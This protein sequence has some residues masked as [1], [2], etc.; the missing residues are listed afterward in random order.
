MIGAATAATRNRCARLPSATKGGAN[1]SRLRRSRFD[2]GSEL[3]GG[4]AESTLAGRVLV[5]AL[6]QVV[7]AELG[8]QDVDEDQLGVRDLPQHEVRDPLLAARAD[9]EVERGQPGGRQV[10][11]EALDVD[12]VG[13]ERAGL[14]IARDRTHRTRDRL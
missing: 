4:E 3:R 8:P 7:A 10:A 14:G 5:E 6:V 13:A 1:L 11:G 9:E 2:V 12:V